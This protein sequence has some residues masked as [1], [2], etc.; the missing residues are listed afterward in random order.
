MVIIIIE[1]F[2]LLGE[3]W[4]EHEDDHILDVTMFCNIK[5][6]QEVQAS[7]CRQP[8]EAGKGKEMW[9]SLRACREEHRSDSLDFSPLW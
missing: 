3:Y 1:N 7:E 2:N 4:L 8:L 5:V 9:F 6:G